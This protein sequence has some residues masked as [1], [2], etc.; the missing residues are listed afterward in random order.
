[1]KT[2]SFRENGHHLDLLKSKMVGFLCFIKKNIT[3]WNQKTGFSGKGHKTYLENV[4]GMI[5]IY[6]SYKKI[7]Q[8]QRNGGIS[9]K[10][11]QIDFF[12]LF[13]QR[14]NSHYRTTSDF[15]V[16]SKNSSFENLYKIIFNQV[17]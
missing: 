5:F 4:S 14:Y 1:M 10:K 7:Q 9:M 13:E 12:F 2:N 16:Q 3:S 6:V 8:V 11:F 17:L 15:Y